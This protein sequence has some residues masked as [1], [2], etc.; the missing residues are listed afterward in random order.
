MLAVD[1][2]G[3]Y[4]DSGIATSNIMQKVASATADHVATL[5]AAGE[6]VDSGIA[7]ADVQQ[8]LAS[9]TAGDILTATAAGFY[10]DSGTALADVQLKLSGHTAGNVLTVAATGFMQDSGVKFDDTGST[11]TDVWSASKVMDYVTDSISGMSWQAPVKAAQYVPASDPAA[12]DRYLITATATGAWAG[13]E[14]QIAE[15]DG[16]EWQY[17]TPVD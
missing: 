5:N 12:G 6:V 4:T 14:D 3:F 16:T 13:K 11:S 8:K 9:A 10:Q 17:T 2:S 15:W 1:A 7:S